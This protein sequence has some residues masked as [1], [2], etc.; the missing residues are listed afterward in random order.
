MKTIT[1]FNTESG[2]MARFANDQNIIELFGTDTIPT[3]FTSK[4]GWATV[5]NEI[6]KL[7][8]DHDVVIGF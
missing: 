6:K 3:S 5:L 4:A 7:N 1:L 2:W 8:P